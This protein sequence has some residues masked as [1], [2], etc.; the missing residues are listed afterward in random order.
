[1]FKTLA[2]VQLT[3]S[4]CIS[5]GTAT[6]EPCNSQSDCSSDGKCQNNIC[7]YTA[8]PRN[9]P[10]ACDFDF[11]CKSTDE[12]AS[13][14]CVAGAKVKHVEQVSC[15][16]ENQ[17]PNGTSCRKMT[18]YYDSPASNHQQG[19][20]CVFDYQCNSGYRSVIWYYLARFQYN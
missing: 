13:P 19:V 20:S 17:C 5:A 10:K 4:L 9:L 8:V 12:C 7:V 2:L 18:C 6:R 16:F 3:K 15:V 11:Q 14:K 1:M